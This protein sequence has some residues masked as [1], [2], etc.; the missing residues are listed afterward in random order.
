LT[1]KKEFPHLVEMQKKYA[2]DGVVAVSVSLDDLSDK[3]VRG[4]IETFLKAQHATFTNLILDE[5][6]EAWQKK[7]GID[8]MPAAFIYNRD[9]KVVKKFK[10]EYTYE[11]V[12]KVVQE[13]LKK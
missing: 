5:D 8:G 13:L 4:R 11:D 9:G 10:D 6:V 7:L 1:C 2:K 3:E 12:E